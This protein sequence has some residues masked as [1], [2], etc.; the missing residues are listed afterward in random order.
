M[1][2]CCVDEC[3]NDALQP[4]SC[5]DIIN[6]NGGRNYVCIVWTQRPVLRG[7]SFEVSSSKIQ[8]PLNP[9]VYTTTDSNLV[10]LVHS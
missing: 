8:A 3:Y 2:S 9:I 4:I 7:K 10:Q 1:L 5:Q 6:G